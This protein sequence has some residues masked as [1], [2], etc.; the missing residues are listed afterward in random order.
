MLVFLGC[1]EF[2]PFDGKTTPVVTLHVS[3]NGNTVISTHISNELVV[4][5]LSNKNK[6]VQSTEA[7]IYSAYVTK[8]GDF[9][10]W[11]DLQN[12]VFVNSLGQG[13]VKKF[14][15]FPVYGHWISNDLG[16][17]VSLDID[18]SLNINYGNKVEKIYSGDKNSFLGAHK[19]LNFSASRSEEIFLTSG[20]GYDWTPDPRRSEKANLDAMR[21]SYK[22]VVLWDASIKKEITRL[23][24][25]AAKTHATLSPDGK[26]VVS[27]DE[28]ARVFLWDVNNPKTPLRMASLFHGTVINP[29]EHYTKYKWDKTGLIQPPKD[30]S[31]ERVITVKFISNKHFLRFGHDNHYA[32]LY[33]IGNPLPLKYLELGTDPYPCVSDYSRNAC[34]DTAPDVGILVMGQ[35]DGGG[36]NV[37]QFD[38]EKLSLE[39]VWVTN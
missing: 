36:I 17:Y 7:N 9:Y 22:G 23:P 39:K 18:W 20:Y 15:H 25:N 13:V 1:Q 37:Y 14:K 16:K 21:L 19:L 26:F 5:D 4:W 27:G 35:R 29:N 38:K 31:G 8:K 24:G 10:L 34:I 11:Q 32:V 28:N 30:Y 3:E 33:E 6:N 2:S 12:T